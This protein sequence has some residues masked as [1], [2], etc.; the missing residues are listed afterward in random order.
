MEML[1]YRSQ[2]ALR[3]LSYGSSKVQT[4]DLKSVSNTLCNRCN[5][6]YMK[7]NVTNIHSTQTQKFTISY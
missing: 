2:D 5:M 3:I 6:C 4:E 7:C 1:D